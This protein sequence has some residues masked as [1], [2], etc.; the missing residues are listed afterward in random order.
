MRVSLWGGGVGGFGGGV[1]G[2]L[3]EGRWDGMGVLM[4]EKREGG[5]GWE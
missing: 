2:D 5:V 4:L 1:G 3:D